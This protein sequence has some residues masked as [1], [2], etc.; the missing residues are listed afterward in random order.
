VA[1]IKIRKASH[2]ADEPISGLHLTIALIL[3]L[4][5]P[6]SLSISQFP[7]ILQVSSSILDLSFSERLPKKG[8][9][10]FFAKKRRCVRRNR[11][12]LGGYGLHQGSELLS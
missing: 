5:L 1:Q 4:L 3:R 10:F 8:S 7:R 2:H 9:H 6:Y 12:G 11:L